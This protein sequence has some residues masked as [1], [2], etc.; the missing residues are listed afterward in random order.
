MLVDEVAHVALPVVD[1]TFRPE[2]ERGPALQEAVATEARR[3]LDLEAAPPVR[4]TLFVLGET[5]QDKY[6]NNV[7]E[8]LEADLPEGDWDTVGGLVY[9]LLGHVPTEGESVDSDGHRLTAERVQGRR[10]G[11]VRISKAAVPGEA[12]GPAAESP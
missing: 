2:A 4:M 7:N 10:I 1:L 6:G 5:E 9:S 12:D 11:R 8:L 3:P